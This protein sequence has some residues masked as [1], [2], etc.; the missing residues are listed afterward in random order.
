MASSSTFVEKVKALQPELAGSTE[1]EKKKIHSLVNEIPGLAKDLKLMPS[2]HSSGPRLEIDF[3]GL[4]QLEQTI[5]RRCQ[6]LLRDPSRSRESI[7]SETVPVLS[8]DTTLHLPRLQSKLESSGY[9]AIPS[10]TRYFDHI[11]HLKSVN[12]ARALLPNEPYWLVTFDLDNMPP[13]ERKVEVK[14]KK[15]KKEGAP[16][17]ATDASAG[18]KDKKEKKATEQTPA[19]STPEAP[20]GK[21]AG[22]SERPQGQK[23]EK[24][25]KEKKPEGAA[26]PA[27][28][29]AT[30][31][32][33]SMIDLRVGKVLEVSRHP[34][35]DSLYVEKIDVGEDEPRIVCSGLVAYMKPEEIQDQTIVVVCNLKPVTMRGVKSFAMLLCATAAEGKEGGIEFVRPPEGSKPGERIYFEGEK[36]ENAQ[37]E[38]LLNPKKK[39]FE[40]VQ[41]AFTTLDNLEAAWVDPETKSVHKIR[42]KDGVCVVRKFKGASLS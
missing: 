2:A 20:A 5:H 18:K 7:S 34:D 9:Y 31:P 38:P 6:P 25:V 28:P 22:E 37:P 17:A 16:A 41:P 39:V 24:K 1:E 11:Q 27:P 26:K 42:T 35:A 29:P 4:P 12:D 19:E 15:A 13:L 32:L 33:P 23:K 8:Y 3:F 21:A 36:F 10:V 30:G 14:E 40:T